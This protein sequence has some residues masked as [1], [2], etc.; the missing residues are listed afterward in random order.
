[1]AVL[2]QWSTERLRMLAAVL[3]TVSGMAH[4]GVLWSW[5]LT[6][7]TVLTA[8]CGAVYLFLGL[9]LFGLSRTSLV[10]G[11]A[12]PLTRTLLVLWFLGF[13]ELAWLGYL[14]LLADA[15]VFSLCA[16]ILQR[17]RHLPSI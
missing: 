7:D 15:L 6:S 11:V 9:G 12:L 17:V 1:M 3:I 2:E 4:I 8:T 16:V 13:T 14:F 5:P 10:L